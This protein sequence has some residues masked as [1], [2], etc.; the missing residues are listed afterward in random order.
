MRVAAISDIHSNWHALS[1]V[2][3]D[4]D[5]NGA[6]GIWFLGDLLGYGPNPLRCWDELRYNRQVPA[7]AWVLGNHDW[8]V[9]GLLGSVV[10]ADSNRLLGDFADHAWPVILEQRKLFKNDSIL[11]Q[12]SQMPIMASPVAGV[13]LAHGMF[14]DDVRAVIGT[15]ANFSDVSSQSLDH[16]EDMI[17]YL[18]ACP[19]DI[20]PKPCL[21]AE[22]WHQPRLMLVGHTHIVSV[23]QAKKR[24]VNHGVWRDWTASLS[25]D[26]D[27]PIWFEHLADAPLFVNPGSVGFPR[28][29]KSGHASYML[30]DWEQDRVGITLRRVPYNVEKMIKRMEGMGVP[31]KVIRQLR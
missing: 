28:D 18:D 8:G 15:Y 19:A 30:I 2:L 21:A 1:A 24:E 25:Q 7:Y 14:S 22:G 12:L 6:E 10:F 27:A 9:L 5:E 13:Y 26:P 4:A 23:L 16:L 11:E 3:R 31:E 20:T 29:A 17:Q